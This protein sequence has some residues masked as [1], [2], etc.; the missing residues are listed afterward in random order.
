MAEVYVVLSGVYED[1]DSIWTTR[2]G[3]D[4]RAAVCG[5][6]YRVEAY[7]LDAVHPQSFLQE[8]GQARPV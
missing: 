2:E 4:A 8:D 1:T 6:T 3:A 5:E 7:P